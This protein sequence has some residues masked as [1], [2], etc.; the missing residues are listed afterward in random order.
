MCNSHSLICNLYSLSPC[1][2]ESGFIEITIKDLENM[3]HVEVSNLWSKGF[4]HLHTDSRLSYDLRSNSLI[5]LG[6]Y[7]KKDDAMLL[8]KDENGSNTFDLV[9][10]KVIELKYKKSLCVDNINVRTEYGI[11][12]RAENA[13]LPFELSEVDPDT[14]TY[15]FK[16][17]D[18]SRPD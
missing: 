14:Q 11:Y 8:S 3:L 4:L 6:K 17:L 9:P 15:T 16:S 1:R 18:T 12:V 7:L 2:L 10:W 5:K 13:I